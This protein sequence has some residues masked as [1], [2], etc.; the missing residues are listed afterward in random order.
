MTKYTSNK[1]SVS[2]DNFFELIDLNIDN[3]PDIVNGKEEDIDNMSYLEIAALKGLKEKIAFLLDKN[4]IN[5]YV[6]DKNLANVIHQTIGG[7]VLA[8]NKGDKIN[9]NIETLKLLLNKEAE[10]KASHSVDIDKTS[11]LEQKDYDNF[12][13]IDIAKQDSEIAAVLEAAIREAEIYYK[14]CLEKVKRGET[15]TPYHKQFLPKLE[16][17]VKDK[18]DQVE[19]PVNWQSKIE[20]GLRQRHT[21]SSNINEE[22]Q[23][24]LQNRND[25]NDKS[26]RTSPQKTEGGWTSFLSFFSR[27]NNSPEVH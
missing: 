18:Q 3:N 25:D 17:P 19:K 14:I 7:L 2:Y 20:S 24:L 4:K 15:F 9:D 22:H 16:E 23:P 11:L 21:S 1:I 10:L 8:K 13:A 6:K 12:T 5:I 26:R 27:N